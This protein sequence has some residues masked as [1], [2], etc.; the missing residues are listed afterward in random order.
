MC[1]TQV[2]KAGELTFSNFLCFGL[3]ITG[4]QDYVPPGYGGPPPNAVRMANS[5]VPFE[6]HVLFILWL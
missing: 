6:L 2:I 1:H 3:Q 4:M 5:L